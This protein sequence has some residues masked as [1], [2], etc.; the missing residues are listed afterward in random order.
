M[1]VLTEQQNFRSAVLLTR[2]AN[3]TSDGNL[4]NQLF[5]ETYLTDIGTVGWLIFLGRHISKWTVMRQ[6]YNAQIYSRLV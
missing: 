1:F 3:A 2:E 5:L 4:I 6:L